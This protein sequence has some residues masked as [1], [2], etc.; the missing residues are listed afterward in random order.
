[1]KLFLF[2][3]LILMTQF[4]SAQHH[5]NHAKHNM[6]MFGKETLYISHLVYKQ[7]HNF[8]VILQIELDPAVRTQYEAARIQFPTDQFV[9][10]LDHM[11]ISQLQVQR[12]QISGSIKR[13]DQAG[14]RFE[15]L[16]SVPVMKYEIIYFDEV[17]L[18]LAKP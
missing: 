17:P 18:S 10:L 4:V 9:L 1:M 7:P 3:V 16:A 14:N 11:D 8:Q 2:S 15:V 12:P 6:V 5:P 13:D